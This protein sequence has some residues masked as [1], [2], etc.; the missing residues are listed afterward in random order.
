MA[1]KLFC[2]WG[3]WAYRISQEKEILRRKMKDLSQ[4]PFAKT[5]QKE[6]LPQLIYDH[7]SLI[8]RRLGDVD[9]A[10]QQNKRV[11]LTLAAPRVDGI[12]IHP[13]ETFSFWHLV[14]RCTR[15]KGYQTGMTIGKGQV[16]QGVGGGMCQF[17]NLIHFMV[18][19]SPLTILEHHHHDSMDLF[20]DFGRQVPFGVGTSIAYNYLDYRVR[21]DTQ[22][23]FQLKTFIDGEY[24]HGQL[25]CQE[26]LPY[27]W[28]LRVE[29]EYFEK[30]G[31]ELYRHNI[32]YRRK[33]DKKTGNYEDTVLM[34]NRARVLYDHSY[35]PQSAIR[36][37]EEERKEES[38]CSSIQ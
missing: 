5:F 24:L 21:N 32:I 10:L 9:M 28:H 29:D 8:L 25:R 23:V 37:Q 38:K 6:P 36:Q 31:A 3:P 34:R 19:H 35:V 15:R 12:L 14:G 30:E 13:G 26:P 33:V 20:P 16:G 7:K 27:C 2:Q 11:N 18:L 4:G 17:T 22:Q 1:R